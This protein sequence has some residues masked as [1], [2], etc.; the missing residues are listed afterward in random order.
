MSNTTL[1]CRN[2]WY[3]GIVR[4]GKK[5]SGYTTK[6]R[7]DDREAEKL[8]LDQIMKVLF[9]LPKKLNIQLINRLFGENFNSDEV[10]IHYGN[11][12]FIK[13]DFNRISGDLFFSIRHSSHINQYP[14]KQAGFRIVFSH[15]I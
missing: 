10:E 12:E 7:L 5:A 11:S 3:I 15:T 9:R 2:S 13:D 14:S 1:I 4:E 8:K 6:E